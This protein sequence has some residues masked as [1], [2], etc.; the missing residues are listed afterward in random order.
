MWKVSGSY[1]VRLAGADERVAV[2]CGELELPFEHDAPMRALTT[3]VGQTPEQI[4][5]IG[6]FRVGLES[7]CVA[8]EFSEVSFVAFELHRLGGVV[9][10]EF[11]HGT[12]PFW[13]CSC[14]AAATMRQMSRST[15]EA[16]PIPGVGCSTG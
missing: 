7:D 13:R 11:G 5:E 8:A 2:V 4:S 9:L 1:V 10:V 14:V 16:A 15:T 12:C 3:I 6:V